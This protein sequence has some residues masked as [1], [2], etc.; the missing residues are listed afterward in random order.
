MTS[1]GGGYI[2]ITASQKPKDE[3]CG[4]GYVNGQR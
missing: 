4:K 1:G 2:N 3:N